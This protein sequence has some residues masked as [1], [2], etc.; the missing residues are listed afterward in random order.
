MLFFIADVYLTNG[1]SNGV[2]MIMQTIIRPPSTENGV[3]DG[4]LTPIP[5]YPLY[6]ALSTLLQ[7]TLVPY[8]LDESKGWECTVSS[9]EQ[10]LGLF[11]SSFPL[12][13]Q[14]H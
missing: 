1:A 10:S 8:Y 11:I 13:I 7:A 5:Q 4:V 2:K 9:L 12:Q 14:A 6:S 3:K